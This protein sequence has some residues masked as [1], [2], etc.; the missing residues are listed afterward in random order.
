MIY[1]SARVNYEPVM[2]IFRG[3][4]NDILICRDAGTIRNCFY[5]V[6]VLKDHKTVKKL[7]RV[8]ESSEHGYDS[9]LDF[10]QDQN[11]YCLVFPHVQERKLQDFYMAGQ[12]P[13]DTCM[14]ICENLVLQCMLSKLPY[15]LLFLV[16]R[17]RQIHL[18]KD[19]N[20]EF[21]YTVD[22]KELDENT[23]EKACAV[24]L[25]EL[26]QKKKT[27]RN[28]EYQ[29][30]SM[31]IPRE[32]YQ[33]FQ[34]LYRDLRLSDRAGK[35]K[36]LFR[37]LKLWWRDEQNGWFRF[38]L[39]ICTILLIFT[40][41]CFISRVIWGDVPFLRVLHNHFKVIGTESLVS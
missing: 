15:P 7:I 27:R 38:L 23:G 29:L 35:K 12:F 40:M 11:Q 10:F 9:C 1:R 2:T 13:L 16:L 25:R 24:L 37:R 30:L 22:L 17:Q 28:T 18:L 20:V 6:L 26:L 34:Q 33:N 8:M 3:E 5:T 21:G 39:I 31:K 36:S 41:A 19:Y 4:V 32:S 14:K